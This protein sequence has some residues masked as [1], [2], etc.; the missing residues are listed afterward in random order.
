MMASW[1]NVY[2]VFSNQ[3]LQRPLP[4]TR[5]I[6]AEL[7]ATVCAGPQERTV[8]EESL[9]SAALHLDSAELAGLLNGADRNRRICSGCRGRGDGGRMQPDTSRRAEGSYSGRTAVM[10]G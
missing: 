6:V 1:R 9:Q 10:T 7:L 3:V 5:S 2:S 4:C 8:A